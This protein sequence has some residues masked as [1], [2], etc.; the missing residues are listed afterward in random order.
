MSSQSYAP[1]ILDYEANTYISL[2]LLPTIPPTSLLSSPW[3]PP[4]TAGH[5]LYY[6]G[7]VGKIPDSHLYE[8]RGVPT[9]AD[10]RSGVVNDLVGWLVKLEGVRD[11]EVQQL[12]KRTK[13]GTGDWQ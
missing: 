1:P 12:K 7:N 5:E 8:L 11:V 4:P 6:C 9:T 10:W 13:R 3:N 2:T